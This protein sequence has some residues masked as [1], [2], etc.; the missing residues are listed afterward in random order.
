MF[1]K[2]EWNPGKNELLKKER[3]ISLL[4]ELQAQSPNDSAAPFLLASNYYE[5]KRFEE[6]AACYQQVLALNPD[7]NMRVNALSQL[8]WCYYNLK[9]IKEAHQ[10]ALQAL[11]LNQNDTA[12]L[13]VIG[14]ILL[15]LGEADQSIQFF[16]QS[17]QAPLPEKNKGFVSMDQ[18]EYVANYFL[19]NAYLQKGEKD[20]AKEAFLLAANRRSTAEVNEKLKELQWL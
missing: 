2:Y 8:A 4:L 9:K 18:K 15:S 17:R 19:G 16:E 3:N 7:R 14:A 6:S 13:N 11:K 12:A 5:L 20:K 10:A 1:M